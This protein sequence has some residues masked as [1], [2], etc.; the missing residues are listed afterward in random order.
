MIEIR[1]ESYELAFESEL[2]NFFQ[3]SRFFSLT[4]VSINSVDKSAT[5]YMKQNF[6]PDYI[7]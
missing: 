5:L 2:Q 4:Y 3:Q 6:D 7:A 1:Y